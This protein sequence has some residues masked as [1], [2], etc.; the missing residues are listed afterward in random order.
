MK[1]L[2]HDDRELARILWAKATAILEDA[3]AVTAKGQG[4]QLT[5]GK[6]VNCAR[7]LKADGHAVQAIAD[8]VLVLVSDKLA[9][10]M[11]R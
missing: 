6:A 2:D 11:Q 8:A 1:G 3:I 7:R 5:R 9:K 10:K 4:A